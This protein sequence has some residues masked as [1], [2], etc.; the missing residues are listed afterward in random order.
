MPAGRL[1][2]VDV[3]AG[4]A[5]VELALEP[6]VLLRQALLLTALVE[7]LA[8]QTGPASTT[9]CATG[10]DHAQAEYGDGAGDDAREEDPADGQVG[11]RLAEGGGRGGVGALQHDPGGDDAS[12]D[13]QQ[14]TKDDH[15]GLQWG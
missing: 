3:G 1:G 11:D 6:G 12:R 2:R 15:D 5:G 14:Q 13:E 4:A 8:L 9:T 7:H 10:Q